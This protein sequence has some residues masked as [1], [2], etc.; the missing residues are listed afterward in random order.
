[1]FQ[2]L[3]ALGCET[4][5]LINS[6]LD[7]SVVCLFTEKHTRTESNRMPVF[8]R[9]QHTIQLCT[10]RKTHVYHSRRIF[11][12]WGKKLQ[13]FVTL[14]PKTDTQMPFREAELASETT[15][16]TNNNTLSSD[17]PLALSNNN[18]NNGALT[19]VTL[20][21]QNQQQHLQPQVVT[22]NYSNNNSSSGYSS[23]ENS[24]SAISLVVK[25]TNNNNNRAEEGRQAVL[26]SVS[27]QRKQ[28]GSSSNQQHQPAALAAAEHHEAI[29]PNVTIAKVSNNNQQQGALKVKS[30]A[31]LDSI[32]AE[33]LK[34][35]LLAPSVHKFEQTVA[36]LTGEK[37]RSSFYPAEQAR[38]QSDDSHSLSS[39]ATSGDCGSD[40]T[41]ACRH[42]DKTFQNKFHLDSH[43]V[44]H[45][46]ERNFQCPECDKTFG[47][48]STLR[49]HMTTH[50]GVSNYMCSMC[51][52]ACNDNN[53]LVEHIRMHTGEK[54][55]ICSIC[56]KAYARKSHLNVHHR[57]ASQC[58][59]S[60]VKLG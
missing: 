25:R 19:L 56:S 29:N 24:N 14:F 4:K 33:E 47:R 39:V 13:H 57:Y 22:I 55:Y 60:D 1:M 23:E 41:Y 20:D 52:K 46:G 45:T 31:K 36:A 15:M 48:R 42:C 43:V 44:V 11:S 17:S 2:L 12:T 49:A 10:P 18:N 28:S 40:G 5:R 59:L 50:T 34:Q 54:P 27:L 37:R 38:R 51:D 3:R 53:S 30:F 9:V 7:C 35:K 16:K 6:D 58:S 32:S 21:R 8:C 26:P